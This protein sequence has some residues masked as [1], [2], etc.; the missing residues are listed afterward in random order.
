MLYHEMSHRAQFLVDPR[1]SVETR[2]LCRL[3]T[4][5]IHH[6]SVLVH[7]HL[8]ISPSPTKQLMVDSH[9]SL[10]YLS[11]LDHLHPRKRKRRLPEAIGT[12]RRQCRHP[13]R[14]IC[15]DAASQP[16]ATEEWYMRCLR[17]RMPCCKLLVTQT[18]RPVRFAQLHVRD[19]FFSLA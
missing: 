13:D 11:V 12:S 18:V 14:Q 19:A 10:L 7:P 15:R 6:G 5:E 8:R 1:I 16:R 17:R 4:F 3:S 9:A 2:R